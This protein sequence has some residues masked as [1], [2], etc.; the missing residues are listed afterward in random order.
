MRGVSQ[1]RKLFVT[2]GAVALITTSLIGAGSFLTYQSWRGL[3][4]TVDQRLKTQDLQGKI[5]WLDEVLTMSARMNAS[6]GDQTWEKRYNDYVPLLDE[7]IGTLTELTPVQADAEQAKK[8]D[9]ANQRLI[10]AETKSFELVSEGKSEEALALLLGEAYQKDKEVYAGGM[11][12]YNDSVNEFIRTKVESETEKTNFLFG[13]LLVSLAI[14]LAAWIFAINLIRSWGRGLHQMA[15]SI[16]E[17]NDELQELNGA[18]EEKVSERTQELKSRTEKMGLILSN[19]EQ[20]FVM[21]SR[22]GVLNTER[23][24]VLDEW[25]PSWKPGSSLLENVK[26]IDPKNHVMFEMGWQQMLD[27]LL[28][29]EMALDQIPSRM[30]SNGKIFHF[31]LRPILDDSG[32]V[33]QVL[34]VVSDISARVA[35]EELERDS[36]ERM[37]SFQL[38]LSDKNGFLE[39]VAET[40]KLIQGLGDSVQLPL[41]KRQLHT[42][43]GNSGIYGLNS[44]ADCCHAWESSLDEIGLE[45][46]EERAQALSELWNERIS[47]IKDFIGRGESNQIEIDAE[48]YVAAIE[49]VR[50]GASVSEMERL[51][52]S[53]SLESAKRRLSRVKSQAQRFAERLGKGQLQVKIEHN[54][55]RYPGAEFADFWSSMIHVVR[56]SLDHGIETPE[57]RKAAGKREEATLSLRAV[58]L[59]GGGMAV[60]VEDNG[61]GIDWETVREKAQQ[62]NL[63]CASDRDLLEALFSDGFSTRD[64]VNDYSGRGVGL[65]AVKA[66][67]E[68]LGGKVELESTVGERTLFRFVF[69]EKATAGEFKQAA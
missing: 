29:L 69:P 53:W 34:L 7:A 24:G 9:M 26:E 63:P 64:V 23:S 66:A 30:E 16:E 61:R 35:Q 62:K 42:I 51:L 32:E 13:V 37:R 46:Q 3:K 44:I 36:K 4:E 12:A 50:K 54:F 45:N 49:R 65:A 39:F 21:V 1:G 15:Q 20:G 60:E 31:G 14:S 25:F 6:T 57:E 10:E 5:I 48:E 67:C 52:S 27:Q 28:P 17:K 19:A 38:I 33:E 41:L 22:G 2:L 56:N 8:T 11:E 47:G 68:A 40:E 18:L 58:P 59:E 43:K 55:M